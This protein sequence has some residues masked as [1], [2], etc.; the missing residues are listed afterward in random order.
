MMKI[1]SSPI[2]SY[3]KEPFSSTRLEILAVLSKL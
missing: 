2:T 1:C 3:K